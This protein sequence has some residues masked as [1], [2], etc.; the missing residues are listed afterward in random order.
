MTTGRRL[1]K[2][3][4][5]LSGSDIVARLLGSI[6]TIYIARTLGAGVFG[7]LSFALAF[8]SYFSFFSDFGLTTL[9]IREIAKDKRKTASY[10][11]NI[12]TLQLILAFI[13]I[14]VV[15]VILYF[16]PLSP[17]IKIITF[18]FSLS[19]I[20]GALNMAYIFQAHEKMEYVAIGKIIAQLGYVIV[21]FI[22]IYLF[23]DILVLPIVSLVA[24]F[25][26]S[27]VI[28]YLLR[29]KIQFAWSRIDWQAIKNLIKKALPF[30]IAALAV[31]IYYNMDSIM[32]QFMK[33][34]VVVGLYNS[35]YKIILLI[36]TFGFFVAGA[37][38]PLISNAF[39]N[40]SFFF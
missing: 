13:L 5:S 31:Q 32:L 12:L 34:E 33:G 14:L 4:L 15:S 35:A 23:K 11:T 40:L 16:L 22:F 18:L 6:L 9:G 17:R 8:T 1:I 30:V 28:F 25:I 2:N 39:K 20:P 37:F 10:G 27:G 24:A 36:I 21:G 3:F 7:Q 19:I 38:F 26:G 29:K